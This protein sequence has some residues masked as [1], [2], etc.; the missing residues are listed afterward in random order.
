MHQV[1]IVASPQKKC[2]VKACPR[3]FSHDRC[4]W[5]LNL[6]P[7]DL[8]SNEVT[9]SHSFTNTVVKA[10]H[11][12]K[13]ITQTIFWFLQGKSLVV[14][15]TDNVPQKFSPSLDT[16]ANMTVKIHGLIPFTDKTYILRKFSLL[17]IKVKY[18]RV[19]V[20]MCVC[21]CVCV[22]V[23]GYVLV[24]RGCHEL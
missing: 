17:C 6:R 4:C 19:Y 11:C 13:S 21:V 12:P 22:C 10:V 8:G 23:W 14:Y 9:V 5:E 15:W 3:R 18:V 1:S 7:L 16:A 2:G 24:G 20:S